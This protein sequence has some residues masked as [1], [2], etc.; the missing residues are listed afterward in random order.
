MTLTGLGGVAAIGLPTLLG[1]VVDGL[2]HGGVG[3]LT[4]ICFMLGCAFGAFATRS[5]DLAI[6]A[7]AAPMLFAIVVLVAAPFDSSGGLRGEVVALTTALATQAP[8][9]LLGTLAAIAI[10]L[11]RGLVGSF[12]QLTGR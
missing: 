2:W 9:L 6:V 5:R 3:A 10:G 12:R 4:G 7:V 11:P 8:W 1:A